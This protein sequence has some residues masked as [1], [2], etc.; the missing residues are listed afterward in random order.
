M[1]K[2]NLPQNTYNNITNITYKGGLYTR[3]LIQCMQW[4]YIRIIEKVAIIA[5]IMLVTSCN[6]RR[7]PPNNFRPVKNQSEFFC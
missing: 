5:Y 7:F 4:A 1:N 3:G 2:Y 6:S